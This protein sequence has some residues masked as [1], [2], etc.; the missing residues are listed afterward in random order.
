M[1]FCQTLLDGG[2]TE[3][4]LALAESSSPS[5]SSASS[6]DPALLS[7]VRSRVG[8]AR[9]EAMETGAAAELLIRAR[10]DSR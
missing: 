5:S 3:Q 8:F 7:D 6:L 2:R 1:F 4:A 9:L 10:V